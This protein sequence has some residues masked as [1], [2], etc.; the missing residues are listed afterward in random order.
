MSLCQNL[1]TARNDLP[2]WGDKE[3]RRFQFRVEL[4]KRRGWS[5][6]DAE[7]WADRLFERD[8]E[9]DD[10]RLC[11]ECKNLQRDGGCFAAK[12]GRLPNTSRH[13]QPI[14]SMLQRCECFEFVKP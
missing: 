13:L 10:R 6:A 8:Y 9:R 7:T 14:T 5:E 1:P 12:Q 3:I 4:F 2:P 11:I